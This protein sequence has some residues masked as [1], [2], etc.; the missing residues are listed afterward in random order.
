MATPRHA[1]REI[2]ERIVLSY[3]HAQLT[4]TTTVK[5]YDVPSGRQLKID[6]VRY[7]NPTGLAEDNDHNFAIAVKNGSTTA[8]GPISTDANLSPDTGASIAADTFTDIA[9]AT[10]GS[11]VF[12]A[13]DVVSVVF[14]E[15]GTATLPAGRI[16]IDG[17]LV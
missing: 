11:E 15:T 13:G 9:V 1:N 6:R 3:D 16:V 7:I 17:T 10:D 14:T 5:I 8:A 2:A 12:D 4:A